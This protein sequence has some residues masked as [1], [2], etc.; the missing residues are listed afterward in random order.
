MATLCLR[1]IDQTEL[2]A[3]SGERKSVTRPGHGTLMRHLSVLITTSFPGCQ[4]EILMMNLQLK[5]SHNFPRWSEVSQKN[6]LLRHDRQR[7]V[8]N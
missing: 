2:S 6:A 5:I 1:I 7:S 3:A 4:K 8:F